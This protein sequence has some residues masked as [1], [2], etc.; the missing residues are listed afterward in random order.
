VAFLVLTPEQWWL[1]LHQQTA[2]HCH[3]RLIIFDEHP[4]GFYGSQ[5]LGPACHMHIMLPSQTAKQPEVDVSKE[6]A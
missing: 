6:W 2:A 3:P 5:H 4:F 1:S